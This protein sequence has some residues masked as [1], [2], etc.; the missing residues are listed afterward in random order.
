MIRVNEFVEKG[1]EL[2]FNQDATE[3]NLLCDLI[4]SQRHS[5]ISEDFIFVLVVISL[6]FSWLWWRNGRRVWPLICLA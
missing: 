1:E 3:R 5:R 2:K 6:K 4:M